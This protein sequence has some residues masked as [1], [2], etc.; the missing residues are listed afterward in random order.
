MRRDGT[1]ARHA[2]DGDHPCR[3]T[4]LLVEDDPAVRSLVTRLLTL[5]NYRLFSADNGAAALLLWEQHRTEIDLLLTDVMMPHGMNGK[6]L[7]AH[8]G[9][10]N[11][12]LKV[13]FTSGYD[14]ESTVTDGWSHHRARFLPKPYRPEQLMQLVEGVL[15]NST[16]VKDEIYAANPAR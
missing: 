11:P 14:I 6:D 16:D 3:A 10:Q 13:I 12:Y 8:C 1:S 4:I 15:A 5:R 2:T 7:A 9:S